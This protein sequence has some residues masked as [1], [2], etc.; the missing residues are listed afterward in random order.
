MTKLEDICKHWDALDDVKDPVNMHLGLEQQKKRIGQLMLQKDSIIDECRKE[1]M[2]ADDNYYRDQA[3]Q[4]EDLECLVERINNHVE[5]MKRAYRTQLEQLQETIEKE[6][7]RIAMETSDAWTHLYDRQREQE[8]MKLDS[9]AKQRVADDRDLESL[10]LGQEE[11]IRSTKTRLEVDNECLQLELQ[12][13][14]ADVLLNTQKLD[15]NFEVLKRREEESV[16]N[17]QRKRLTKLH[18]TIVELQ[19]T[20]KET[21]GKGVQEGSKLQTDIAKLNGQIKELQKSASVSSRAN[22]KKVRGSINGIVG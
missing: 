14:K 22:D 7:K 2:A 21:D 9:Q 18:D 11:L 1:L 12:K 19:R 8:L 17:Q 13:T 20:L 3:K 6:R 5:T 16:R 15:Y 10:V 4:S